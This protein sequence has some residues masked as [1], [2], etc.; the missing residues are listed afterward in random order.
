MIS[1]DLSAGFGQWEKVPSVYYDHLGDIAHRKH[2]GQ[3]HAGPYIN[4]TGRN[5]I[6]ASKI[7]RDGEHV[8][9]YVKTAG[10][11]T[12]HTDPNWM[13]LFIDADQKSETGWEGYDYLVNS[14]VVSDQVTT[15]KA[16]GKRGWGKATSIAYACSG[17]E[18]M[19]EI[20]R[21]LLGQGPLA[22]DFHWAD[23]IQEL[24]DITEFFLNGDNA[25]ERRSNYRYEE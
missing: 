15:L 11:I 7:A 19:I 4:H 9:F 12:P 13:L 16:W 6:V 25:P 24:A 20:P 3:G 22:I 10:D 18:M 2:P 5:D 21:E 8:Y 14:E 17:K 1:I 23:N